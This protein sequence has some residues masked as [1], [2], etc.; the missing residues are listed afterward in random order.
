MYSKVLQFYVYISF[1]RFFSMIGYYKR[2]SLV[3][4]AMQ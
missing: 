1:F 4:W 2:L 3:P